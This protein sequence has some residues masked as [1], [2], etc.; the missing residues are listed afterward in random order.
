MLLNHYVRQL[1]FL[2]S[3]EC[4]IA[5]YTLLYIRT[6]TALFLIRAP[7]NYV[8]YNIVSHQFCL[9]L[10]YTRLVLYHTKLI[11]PSMYIYFVVITL[12]DYSFL[13]HDWFVVFCAFQCFAVICIFHESNF[14][15]IAIKSFQIC[16]LYQPHSKYGVQ[17]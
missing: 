4:T 15:T 8:E 17:Y 3:Y 10:V 7:C 16:F 9:I 1:M 12:R 6:T 2:H 11:H 5:R 13:C 14:K